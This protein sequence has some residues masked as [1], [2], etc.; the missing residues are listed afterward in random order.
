M[1]LVTTGKAPLGYRAIPR[2]WVGGECA[3]A[4]AALL[5]VSIVWRDLLVL[6][7]L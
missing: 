2:W 7:G 3:T 4:Q 5:P 6:R 1:R